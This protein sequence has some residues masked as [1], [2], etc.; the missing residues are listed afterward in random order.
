MTLSDV[1]VRGQTEA[2][3]FEVALPHP[4][5]KV[6][7]TLTQP[8]LLSQW[9]LPVLD[10]HLAPGAAFTYRTHPQPGWDGTVQCR[11]LEVEKHR[12][13]SYTWV[14][15]NMLDTVVTFTLTATATGT[16]LSL[17]HAGFREDQKRN[18]GG[19]R[20]GWRMMGE[21]LVDLLARMA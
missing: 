15:G 2:I 14:V 4:P 13:I 3:A 6:W 9:L 8:E 1:T 7:R 10:L 18:A 12:R 20:H 11:V 5:E 17:V 19:A 16:H 21:R